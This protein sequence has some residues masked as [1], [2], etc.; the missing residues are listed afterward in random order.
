MF[1]FGQA[2]PGASDPIP[3]GPGQE[4]VWDYPRP[5][6]LEPCTKP[7]EIQFNGVTI[8]R[9]D[10]A[11]RVLETSHPPTYYFPPDDVVA[12]YLEPNPSQS[13]CEWKGRA[14]YVNVV[15]N[16][17]RLEK[18]GWYYPSPT[19]AF[20]D[21]QNY[22]AFYAEPMDACFVDGEQ[23]QPQPGNFYGGWV[24]SAIVG[25]FKGSPGTWGW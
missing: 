11:L 1:F 6:R 18:V 4:S 7:L 14:H 23:V 25:P 8:A 17:R 19:P 10:R 9:T 12:D 21:L 2:K 13:Y 22:L 5:P 15:V 20:T 24:T 16:D 3:P